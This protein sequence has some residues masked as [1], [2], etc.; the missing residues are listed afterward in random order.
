MENENGDERTESLEARYA[1]YA[2]IGHN[3]FEF[4]F[5]FGQCYQTLKS[6]HMHTRIVMSP[7]CAKAFFETL[8][9]ALSR[10][11][12]TFGSISTGEHTEHNAE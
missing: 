8:E 5:D 10:Y 12:G 6:T 7:I 2:E 11:E 3:A 9:G 1:N 4:L